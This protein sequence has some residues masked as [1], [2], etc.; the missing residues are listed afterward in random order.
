V[1]HVT[2]RP[3][4]AGGASVLRRF[5]ERANL[6]SGRLERVSGHSLRVGMAQD[7]IASGA[8]LPGVMQAGRWRT[9]AMPALY[10]RKL[11]AGRGAVA[12]YHAERRL[13]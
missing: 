1:G 3:L 13:G 6:E 12:R 9:A 10:G 5:A 11:L 2:E 7:L 4:A 8:D